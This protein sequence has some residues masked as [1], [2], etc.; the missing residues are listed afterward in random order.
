MAKRGQLTPAINKVAQDKLGREITQ[1]E[2]RLM[3][4]V[5]YQAMNGMNVEPNKV[6][7]EERAI[8]MQWKQEG[9]IANPSTALSI[10]KA[11]Y[12]AM[13]EILWLGY[14]DYNNQA[15]EAAA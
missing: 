1:R 5:H 4:Y 11:F 7:S 10:T 8:L 6:N 13:N 12:D 9:Y 3:P 14:V 15:D 2:L